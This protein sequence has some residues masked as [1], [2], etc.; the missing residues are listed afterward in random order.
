MKR[1][2]RLKAKLFGM[3]DRM[4]FLE[5]MEIIKKC[6]EKYED[7]TM[8]LKFGH[9]LNELLSNISIV[10][11]NDDLIIGRVP[12]VLPTEE[13][14]RWFVENR[15]AYS[16]FPWF[17]TTGHLTVSWET[18]LSEGVSGIRERAKTQLDSI[19]GDDGISLSKRDFLNGAIL[20]CNAIETYALRYA[21]KAEE[22]A[23][24]TE[25][26]ERKIELLRIA[27]VC[28]QVPTY[29]AR[30]FHEAIQSVWLV[31]MIMHAVVGERDF[32]LGR[33]DQYLYP[34]YK[35]DLTAGRI[36][37]EKAQELMECLYIK[38]SEIIG[39]ADQ[40]SPRKRS[41]C[42][43]SVQYVILGG[44]TPNGGDAS[45]PLSAICL[46]AGYL[47]LKQPTIKVRYFNG[48]DGTFWKE[49]CKLV[50]AGGSIG[51]YNDGVQ[52]PAFTSVG[53]DPEDARGYVLYG[54]CNPNVPGKEGSMMYL[55]HSL[56]KYLELALNNGVDP[57]T[58]KQVGPE[59]GEID[60]F[61][62][63][64]DLL[65]AFRLQLRHVLEAE[66]EKHP[67]LTDQDYAR[68]SFTLE[69]IFLEDCIENGREWRLGGA[70]YWH[71][72]QY[73]SG[74]AT[75][76][77]SLAAIQKMVFESKE[78]SLAELRTILNANFQGYEPIR[79]R[80]LNR[81][82]K[83]GNDDDYVDEIAVRVANMFCDEV[84]RCNEVP[85]SIT[86]WPEIYT[87]HQNKP[88]GA[89]LGATPDG[90]KRGE[91]ISENQSPNYGM[92]LNGATA[93]LSSIA[94]LPAHRTPGGGTNLKVHPSMVNGEDG[95]EALSN[96][97]KTYFEKGGLHLQLNIID[98]STLREAQER[99][100]EY[101]TLSVRVVGYSAYFVAL[102][103]KAQN[104]IIQQ[105]EHRI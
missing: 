28:R 99:P 31:D 41:L 56:P 33:I 21:Q 101:K 7:Y 91:N 57:L 62:S 61:E 58:G 27:E 100:D 54:C 30:T 60:Q 42:Q 55:W 40:N 35:G 93:C 17:Q 94:K 50:R 39:Y 8:G 22:L 92:D 83:Y 98:S 25:S 81:C 87:Y 37:P 95:L 32:A 86:F 79:Q 59:T 84:V 20:C 44:Q 36:T 105:T 5:R 43:D 47:K 10:I 11:D 52:I 24:A 72:M 68:C 14:E 4:I 6:A 66:R 45:N 82:P 102:S 67:L 23:Q 63:L 1:T 70:K 89:Q 49:A 34:F 74:I 2:W 53:V 19:L 80:L 75:V 15:R 85:H 12:E 90:R 3:D 104:D 26:E 16:R 69:S 77:D 9:T 96:L 103:K 51:I 71:K 65:E 76:A 97:L 38:C 46:K 78:I 18:L 48:I 29:P 64:D 73:G 13:Q 88:L